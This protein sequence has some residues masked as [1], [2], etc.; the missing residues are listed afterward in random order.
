MSLHA[1]AVRV[2]SRWTAPDAVQ[3]LRRHGYLDHLA[4]CPDGVWR[5]CAP[6]HITASAL[7]IDRMHERVLLTLHHKVRLWLQMGGHCEPDD[8][9]L[10]AAA[11]REAV[12]E[13]GIASLVL[14]PEPVALDRHEVRCGDPD[15]PSEHLDVQYVALAPPGAVERM[16]GE[17]LDLRWFPI[18]ALPQRTDQ[19]LRHLVDRAVQVAFT[20]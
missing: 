5:S 20:G 8:T 10:Y 1:D 2:L 9:S 14:L 16:S 17:S 4:A 18:D 19:A 11:T 7:V 13:S 3:D 6:A 12:E 15:L